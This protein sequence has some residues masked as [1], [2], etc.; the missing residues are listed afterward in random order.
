M[1][2][3]RLILIR[4]EVLGLRRMG[5][6]RFLL[7]STRLID[8]KVL[9]DFTT[10]VLACMRCVYGVGSLAPILEDEW[11]G[12]LYRYTDSCIPFLRICLS[13][14]MLYSDRT[15]IYLIYR[16]GHHS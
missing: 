15:L 11:L 1:E 2:L 16:L 12:F 14:Y 6:E 3:L 4:Q 9:E 10:K 8:M 5:K 13:T 7:L